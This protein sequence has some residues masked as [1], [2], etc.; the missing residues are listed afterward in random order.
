MPNT[1]E[2]LVLYNFPLP[3]FF[4]QDAPKLTEIFTEI[5]PAFQ[6][7]T[8]T[9]I[10]HYYNSHILIYAVSISLFQ[11]TYDKSE[12]PFTSPTQPSAV[13]ST[14]KLLSVLIYITILNCNYFVSCHA[15]K[16]HV[17]VPKF[18]RNS[19]N[20]ST[21]QQRSVLKP[22]RLILTGPSELI[23]DT[24][25]QDTLIDTVRKCE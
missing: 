10:N 16:V 6:S 9:Y 15:V 3:H 20:K 24:P 11:K 7:P 4:S 17:Q 25:V 2:I 14:I 8:V 12:T 13:S 21:I 18:Y 22:K 5:E 1:F 19:V 23:G